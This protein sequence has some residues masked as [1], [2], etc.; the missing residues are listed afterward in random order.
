[1]ADENPEEKEPWLT[2]NLVLGWKVTNTLEPRYWNENPGAKPGEHEVDD[3]VLTIP[4]TIGHHTVI[5]AQSGSGKSYFL[6]RLIEEILIKT[7]SRVLV[8]DTNSDF[9]KIE[10]IK[11]QGHWR[12]PEHATPQEKEKYK[13]YRYPSS[14]AFLADE[15][16]RSEFMRRWRRVVPLLHTKYLEPTSAVKE[17][18]PLK[19]DWLK[20][21]A[22]LLAEEAPEGLRDEV[23]HCHR[24]VNL[25]AELASITQNKEWSGGFL[26]RALKFCSDTKEEAANGQE[27]EIAE[28]LKQQ[29]GSVKVPKASAAG[30]QT[31]AAINPQGM[32]RVSRRRASIAGTFTKDERITV[33]GGKFFLRVSRNLPNIA[34]IFSGLQRIKPDELG[35]VYERAAT[36]RRFVSPE[37][38]KFYFGRAFELQ[39]SGLVDDPD[40]LGLA[41]DPELADIDVIDLPSIG[42]LRLQKIAICTFLEALWT[43]ARAQRDAALGQDADERV[44]TFVVLE[45]AHNIVPGDAVTPIDK[46]LREEFRRIA[47]EGRKYGL[48]LVLISQRPDKIDHVVMSECENRA[49][50]KVG[51]TLVLKTTCELLGLDK[52]ASRVTDKVVGFKV[53]RALLAGPWVADQPALLVAAARRTE[54][55]GGNLRPEYWTRS[56]SP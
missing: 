55:G 30:G 35:P 1:M 17:Y 25:L 36:S 9:R 32:I 38:Q 46:K 11:E 22:D 15:P 13:E 19:L 29:F 7:S 28:E 8:F 45:E 51:S 14:K 4:E 42:D 49:V 48:Y 26:H 47:A 56:R 2:K 37:A 53:G 27:S 24:L 43:I 40:V 41:E 31:A 50:M 10:L 20:F 21:P 6:G 23:R 54:E 12:D 34:G 18:K 16:S 5:I 44:P 33:E 39:T 3:V 52:V